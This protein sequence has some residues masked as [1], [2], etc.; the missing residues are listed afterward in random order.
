[1][2][3]RILVIASDESIGGKPAVVK[4]NRN[5]YVDPGQTDDQGAN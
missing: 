1:L 3:T 2:F 4:I 5:P